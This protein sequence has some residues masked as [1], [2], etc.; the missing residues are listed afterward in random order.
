MNE[1]SGS[2]TIEQ[3]DLALRDRLLADVTTR[4]HD[5][6][7]TMGDGT[8]VIGWLDVNDI[9]VTDD[10]ARGDIHVT[11]VIDPDGTVHEWPEA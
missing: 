6:L 3:M 2:F 7:A 4:R 5:V 11:K 10:F 9:E 8:Q 1:I